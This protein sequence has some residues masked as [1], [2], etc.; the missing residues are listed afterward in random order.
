[1]G[2]LEVGA[3]HALFWHCHLNLATDH[4]GK[5]GTV[6]R[7]SE[8]PLWLCA[9]LASGDPCWLT[10][11]LINI[12]VQSISLPCCT[13]WNTNINVGPFGIQLQHRKKGRQSGLQRP[14]LSHSSQRPC[15]CQFSNMFHF[16]KILVKIKF[17]LNIISIQILKLFQKS[18]VYSSFAIQVVNDFGIRY[19]NTYKFLKCPS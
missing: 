4:L 2:V 18:N 13:L 19:K 6:L 16:R 3:Y 11:G 14:I 17:T 7:G 15:G 5:S 8:A 9:S 12:H 1:M 10:T